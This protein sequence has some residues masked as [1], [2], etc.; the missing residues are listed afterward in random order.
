MAKM[1]RIKMAKEAA[2]KKAKDEEERLNK[3]MEAAL[4]GGGDGERL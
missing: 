2:E 1:E 3:E 4:V